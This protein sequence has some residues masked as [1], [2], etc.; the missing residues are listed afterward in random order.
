MTI[1]SKIELLR[2]RHEMIQKGLSAHQIAIR[3]GIVLDLKID[4]IFGAEF[5]C[6][7]SPEMVSEMSAFIEYSRDKKCFLDVGA[8]D[9]L[10]SLVFSKINPSAKVYAFE[11]SHEPNTR[12]LYNTHNV[13]DIDCIK[14]ALSDYDGDLQMKMEWEHLVE[15][16][17][18][19]FLVPCVKG[20]TF[21]QNE[22]LPDI[23]KIDT[24]GSELKVLEGLKETILSC[25]PLIFLELHCGRL[26]S[27]LKNV[28]DLIDRWGYK[29]IDSEDGIEKE[30]SPT[31]L[32]DKRLIL[33]P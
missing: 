12:L 6:Y 21:F 5:F 23:I 25:R 2:Q 27:E 1:E 20:D 32:I 24:E 30:I 17:S 11:P 8:Y 31:E 4:C 22:Q 13:G 18:G 26:G 16:K 29:I 14:S 33:M 19:D 15:D 9:G 28:L 3:Q 7:R 10:F